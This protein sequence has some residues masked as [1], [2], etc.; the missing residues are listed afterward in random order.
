MTFGEEIRKLRKQKGLR[1]ADLGKVV[2]VSVR[3]IRGWENEGRYPRYKELYKKLA[4]VLKCDIA[5]LITEEESFVAEPIKQ[6]DSSITKEVQTILKQIAT[7]FAEGNLSDT[8]QI[9]FI[10]EIQ[11]LY[12][13]SKKNMKYI[14]ST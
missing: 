2:G 4:I 8:D 13:H 11:I 5:Y 14:Y 12:L 6:Y 7:L 9:A 3:T 10:N 1:Q